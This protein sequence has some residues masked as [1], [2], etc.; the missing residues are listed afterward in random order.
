MPPRGKKKIE[1]GLQ[2]IPSGG[3][4]NSKEEFSS[5]DDMDI[6]PARVANDFE[7]QLKD[8][9]GTANLMKHL[10]SPERFSLEISGEAYASKDGMEKFK[11]ET[12]KNIDELFEIV[13][14]NSD[15]F[16]DFDEGKAKKLFDGIKE[17]LG[18][19]LDGVSN[20]IDEGDDYHRQA[21]WVQISVEKTSLK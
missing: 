17:K 19:E 1:I 11:K 2:G 15:D 9:E 14:K 18:K 5:L 6:D 21:N 7:M 4:A 3:L 8:A 16:M 12:L 13:K 10:Q 20:F